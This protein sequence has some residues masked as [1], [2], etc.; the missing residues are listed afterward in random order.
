M[1]TTTKTL[2]A[3]HFGLIM[4]L[5]AGTAA[6]DG[7]QLDAHGQVRVRGIVDSSRGDLKDSGVFEREYLTQRARA[8]LDLKSASS[9]AWFRM[10]L[11]DARIWGEET[12]P[13][14]DKTANGLDVQ[15][16]FAVLPLVDGLTLKVGRQEIIFD[17]HRLMGNVGWLQRAQS[18][19]AAK[20]TFKRDALRVDAFWTQVSERDSGD[21]EGSVPAGRG[22]DIGLLGLRA[23]YTLAKTTPTEGKK[24]KELM[25]AS[26]V[27][28]MRKND[29]TQELRHTAGG[30][31]NGKFGGLKTT[32]E[33]YMQAGDLGTK[34][35]SS[36]L[37]AV[38]VGYG[39]GGAIKPSL[40]LFADYLSGDGTA[41]GTFDTLYATNHKFYGEM[42]Y[43]L[44]IPKHTGN[45]GLIDAGAKL[46]IGHAGPVKLMTTFHLLSTVKAEANDAKDLGKELDLKV[47]WPVRKGLAVRAL[48]GMFMPGEAMGT[49]KGFN[50]GDALATEHFGYLTVD[51][52]F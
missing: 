16:A 37:A 22:G 50:K 4:L 24:V 33:A 15:E 7:W 11:Q 49:L 9:K 42:D 43:F 51:A 21:N 10:T 26:L 34:S 30:I 2:I 8:R 41:E 35:I 12:S 14:N 45:L 38:N 36:Q 17:N 31:F 18:F 13:L 27:Y 44:A 47:I 46:V 48:W 29:A 1:K 20:V 19:D 5:C 28:L 39:L 32:L 40:S 23:H 6:A 3:G 25:G 52:T